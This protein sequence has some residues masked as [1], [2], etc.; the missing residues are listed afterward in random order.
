MLTFQHGKTDMWSSWSTP[1]RKENNFI[2]FQRE[3]IGRAAPSSRN[4]KWE[5][6]NGCSTRFQLWCILFRWGR[7]KDLER[8]RWEVPPFFKPWKQQGTGNE[9][10]RCVFLAQ[11]HIMQIANADSPIEYLISNRF[12]VE[13]WRRSDGLGGFA[14][15]RAQF[16]VSRH[17]L[18]SDQAT[19]RLPSRNCSKLRSE[20]LQRHKYRLVAGWKPATKKLQVSKDSKGLQIRLTRIIFGQ[21]YPFHFLMF[22]GFWHP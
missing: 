5:G 4:E 18:E 9:I 6:G 21:R 20:K 3:G 2:S 1:S 16:S 19:M 10:E 13:H 14:I 12:I 7:G 22:C 15:G 17:W 8:S 11:F